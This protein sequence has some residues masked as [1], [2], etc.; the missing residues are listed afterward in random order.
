[1]K[2][3]SRFIGLF[4]PEDEFKKLPLAL[5]TRIR[6]QIVL[7][8]VVGLY[9][10]LTFVSMNHGLTSAQ[11]AWAGLGTD[12]VFAAALFLIHSRR[13]TLSSAVSNTGLF[14]DVCWAG[15]LMP[16]TG[17]DAIYRFGIY[18][19]AALVCGS[20][21]SLS[22]RQ[23]KISAVCAILLFVSFVA[24]EALPH[25]GD[26]V[27]PKAMS[28]SVII[29][30]LTLGV[31][32]LL[33]AVNRLDAQLVTIAEENSKRSAERAAS[34]SALVE[35]SRGAFGEAQELRAAFA[36]SIARSHEIRKTLESLSSDSKILSD[37]AVSLGEAGKGIVEGAHG[38]S[39]KVSREGVLLSDTLESLARI[40]A[41]AGELAKLADAKKEAISKVLATSE[42]ERDDV[43]NLR[44]AGRRVSEST[45]KVSAA[46]AGIA[47]LSEKTGLLAMNASIEAA[48]AGV[49]GKGFAV[50][51]QEVRKLSDETKN[52]TEKIG[53]ALSE[54]S[55]SAS[56]SAEAAER[57]ASEASSLGDDIAATFDALN[58]ILDGLSSVS[59]EA[60][61][62]KDRASQLTE[63]AKLAGEQADGQNSTIGKSAA[64]IDSVGLFSQQLAGRV[65]SI[66]DDFSSIESAVEKAKEIGEKSASHMELLDCRLGEMGRANG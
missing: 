21:L 22:Q 63:I 66:L 48:H 7:D 14:L 42:R 44:E 60:A 58:S 36:D 8:M 33:I 47:D 32:L 57:F 20:L 18:L 50:I 34:L 51:S 29:L 17:I 5:S 26:E 4:F 2:R 25:L 39:D 6:D 10:L 45:A 1:M 65:A 40:A 9:F 62:L 54:S 3:Y 12:A 59:K 13:Y 19:I 49:Y 30:G 23:V 43:K 46:A 52:Q 16:V 56:A 28:I 24:V 55:E 53:D 61:D 35:D 64:A 11:Y 37:D 27:R 38:V 15:F 41:T 31:E